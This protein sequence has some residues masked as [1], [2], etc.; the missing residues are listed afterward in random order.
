MLLSV[1]RF[2]SPQAKPEPLIET[3]GWRLSKSHRYILILCQ[4]AAGF[5]PLA[6]GDEMRRAQIFGL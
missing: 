6:E 2:D 1:V 5:I 4:R 3:F